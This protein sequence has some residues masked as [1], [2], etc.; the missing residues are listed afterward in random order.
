MKD[1]PQDHTRKLFVLYD[2]TEVHDLRQIINKET[3]FQDM[4]GK[5]QVMQNVYQRMTDVAPLDVS[6]LITGGTGTGKELAARAIHSLSRRKTKSFVAINCAGLTETLLGSQLFGHKKGAFTGAIDDHL[7]LFET[8][9][10]GTL[11]LDEIG[12]MP[13]G[14]QATLLRA[15]QEKENSSLRGIR[16]QKS[17]RASTGSH[18]C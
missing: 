7:G 2:T 15:L 6:V 16:C 17:G 9:N 4:V 1:D 5:S 14:I 18:T 8:A 12:D 3:P 11:F 13:L 10:E